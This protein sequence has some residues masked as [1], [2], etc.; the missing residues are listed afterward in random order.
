MKKIL[1]LIAASIALTGATNAVSLDIN[2]IGQRLNGWD[3]KDIATYTI[4]HVVYR[5]Y[6]P[7]PTKSPGGG[8]FVSMRMDS[9]PSRRNTSVCYLHVTISPQGYITGLQAKVRLNG[10]TYDSGIVERPALQAKTSEGE[11]PVQNLTP[12]KGALNQMTAE[13]FTRLDA[14]ILDADM[15]KKGNGRD[16]WSRLGGTDAARVNVS[17]RRAP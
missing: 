15:S 13:L 1:C 7:V 9:V 17:T 11:E 4:D 3:K 14:K 5:T 12:W 8:L 6:K 10:K 2:K 16:I